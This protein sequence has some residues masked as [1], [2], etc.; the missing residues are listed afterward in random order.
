MRKP[1]LHYRTI[2]TTDMRS[3]GFKKV[4]EMENVSKSIL[5]E[6]IND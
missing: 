1:N 6:F 2:C 4:F 3:L 5:G